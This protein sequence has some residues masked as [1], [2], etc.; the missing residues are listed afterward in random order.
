MFIKNAKEIYGTKHDFH[1]LFRLITSIWPKHA[2]QN[3]VQQICV[4][5]GKLF[6]P[7]PKP[8]MRDLIPLSLNLLFGNSIAFLIADFGKNTLT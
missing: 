6:C 1:L 4:S 8:K 5:K 7:K 2:K 3:V